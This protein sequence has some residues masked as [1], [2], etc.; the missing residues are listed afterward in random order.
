MALSIKQARH[1][2]Q[3]RNKVFYRYMKNEKVHFLKPKIADFFQ[4][5]PEKNSPLFW[6]FTVDHNESVRKRD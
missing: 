2:L 5:L 6:I 1:D 4:N 3:Q